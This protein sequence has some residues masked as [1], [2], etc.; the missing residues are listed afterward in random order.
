MQVAAAKTRVGEGEAQ[1]LSCAGMKLHSTRLLFVGALLGGC[2]SGLADIRPEPLRVAPPTADSEAK[3]QRLVREM[4]D[5]HGLETWQTFD[6]VHARAADEWFN[7][8]FFALGAPYTENPEHVV[9]AAYTQRFPSARVEF[10]GGDNAGQV[11]V[12]DGDRIRTKAEGEAVETQ[13][14]ADDPFFAAF[15]H[16][17]PLWPN[18]PFLLASA[19][20]AT[21]L[22]EATWEGRTYDRVLISWGDYAPQADV[23]QWILWVNRDTRLLERV[24]FTIRLAGEDQVGGYNLREIRDVQG[25]KIATVAEGLLG[26]DEDPLHTY[27]YRD[28]RF[29]NRVAADL[30]AGIE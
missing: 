9:V 18:M 4:L 21:Y 16:N 14:T 17:F 22:D 29:S 6:F 24:W 27:T 5:A 2:S 13:R 1:A 19:D 12:V 28:I 3:G 7:A 30:M 10:T 23:D 8:L 15:V 20:R 25:M 11:W 26:L